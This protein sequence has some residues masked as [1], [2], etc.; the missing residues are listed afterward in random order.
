MKK[1]IFLYVT[2]SLVMF[3]IKLT[4][5][6][7]DSLELDVQTA[8]RIALDE[9]P[10]VKVAEMEVEKKQYAKKSTISM[11][12]PQI[13]LIG[14]YQRA[15]KRQTVYFDEGFGIG[16]DDI[17]F[18]QY[19]PEELE[20]LK[21]IGKVMA[22]NPEKSKEGIQMGRFNSYTAGINVSL[23][24]VVPSL[25]KNIQMSELDI[26]LAMEQARASKLSLVNQVKKAFY[27]LLLAN[28]SYNVFQE[29]YKNDSLQ[30]ENI[31]N[32][33][34]QGMV[35]E[36]DLITADVRL[37][38]LIPNILQA[39]N[40]RKIA[41]LQLKML[42]G[43][44]TET[45]IKAHGSLSDYKETMFTQLAPA[46]TSL[47][48]NS[49]MKQFEMQ[50]Q[51]AQNAHQLHKLQFLPTLTSTFNY[52]YMSQSN[53]FK[54]S[55][56]RWDPFSMLGVTLSIPL[57]H[58]GKRYFDTKQSEI[59]LYQMEEQRKNMERQLKLSIKNNFHLMNKNI[60]QVVA[61]QTAVEQ[62]KRGYN[63]TQKRYETGMGTIVDLNAAALA[64]TNAEL[65]Y[66]NA[67]YDYLAAKADLEQTLGYD[68]NEQP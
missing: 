63:I 38:S 9:N 11:L 7:A 16:H 20:V 2:I 3:S 14:Q 30:L 35:A 21:V 52:S 19:T 26:Q 29:T 53:D 1:S 32:R 56:Y 12:L 28:D 18:S 42:L 62:A 22:P 25:W 43:L 48:H 36:Y 67:V 66:R 6:K 31:R 39:D 10:T 61:T 33:F 49:E 65:Q 34:K 45:P 55:D 15:I 13:D 44:D 46:D 40:M 64:V 50:M 58:G 57:F 4:A 47:I 8:I 17:D 60:E 5:Q 51:Q 54:F 37:K 23:P 68:I 59:Q 24:L 41:E 27:S